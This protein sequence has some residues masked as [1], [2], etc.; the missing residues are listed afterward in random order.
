[1]DSWFPMVWRSA[2]WKSQFL[3]INVHRSGILTRWDLN[4][5]DKRCGLTLRLNLESGAD[6][7]EQ[8][9]IKHDSP[10]TV[11]GHVHG[12]QALQQD[13]HRGILNV[14]VKKSCI[15]STLPTSRELRMC[16]QVVETH[17]TGHSVRTKLAKAQW[18]LDPPQQGHHIKVLYPTPDDHTH[19]PSGAVNMRERAI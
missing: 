16:C 13:A 18:G 2:C 10:I 4:V 8:G 11:E 6:Q 1:M 14:E 9:G 5:V 7:S 17:L 12:H 15:F 3:L 19:S